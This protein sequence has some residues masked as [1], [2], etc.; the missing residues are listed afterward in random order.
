MKQILTSLLFIG[1]V[2]HTAIG[3]VKKKTDKESEK[4]T[5]FQKNL[6]NRDIVL[7]EQQLDS[8][9][10]P[11]EEK[12]MLNALRTYYKSYR[13]ELNTGQQDGPNFT[14][15]SILKGDNVPLAYLSFNHE[16]KFRLQEIRMVDP[17][18]IDQYGIRVGDSYSQLIKKR[19]DNFKSSID[20]HQHIYLYS[21]NSTIFYELTGDISMTEDML[22][23]LQELKLTEEQLQM[24]K[25]KSIFWRKQKDD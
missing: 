11:F 24:C 25:V 2:G 15:F 12:N 22:E 7:F 23:N 14:Y 20:Y 1:L 4:V 9:A 18:A 17:I 3:Q 6:A 21:E 16:H 8:F 10:L 5:S 13:V 19:K